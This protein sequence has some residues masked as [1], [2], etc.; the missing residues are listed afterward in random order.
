MREVA[1]VLKG[2]DLLGLF[3]LLIWVYRVQPLGTHLW[4]PSCWTL[5][6]F[7]LKFGLALFFLIL[8]RFLPLLLSVPETDKTMV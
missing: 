6:G 3:S 7:I 5:Y 1:S 4:T 2:A 8:L